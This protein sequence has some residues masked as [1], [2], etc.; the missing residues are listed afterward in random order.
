MTEIETLQRAKMYM[1]KLANGIN[2][3]D[4]TVIPDNDIVNNVRLSRCFFYVADVLRKVIEEESV[5]KK[6]ESRKKEPYSI[7]QAQRDQVAFSDAPIG[8]S[9]LTK[10][11]NAHINPEINKKLSY[12]TLTNWLMDVGMLEMALTAD[13]SEKKRPSKQGIMIGITVEDRVG[14]NGPYQAVVYNRAAQQFI[15]DNLDGVLEYAPKPSES[16]ELQGTPWF[17][18]HDECLKDLYEKEVPVSEIAATL[19]RSE[20]AIR[21]RLKRLGIIEKRSDAN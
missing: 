20:T 12:R 17:P 10:R 8:I 7:T 15:V 14:S 11:L 3:I 5:P 9:E 19:K 13:G 2:P 18:S 1:D 21:A 6:K 16:G 4:D